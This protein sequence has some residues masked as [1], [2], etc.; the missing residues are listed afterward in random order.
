MSLSFID[1]SHWQSGINVAKAGVGGAIA[2]ATDG[3][4]MV[5]TTCDTYVRQAKGAGMVWGVYHFAH[6][7]S[8]AEA[9]FFLRNTTG[10]H[11]S[12][13][14]VLDWEG[15]AVTHGPAAAKRWLDRVHAATGVRPWIYMSRS[16]TEEYDWSAV[17]RDYGLWVA[18][19]GSSSYG[20][21]GKFAH[22][23]A[24]QY[25][26]TGRVPGYS[27]NV[28]LDTFYG[29]RTAWA[30]YATGGKNT[31]DQDSGDDDMPTWKNVQH[32][33][34]WQITADGDW[35]TVRT[36][37]ADDGGTN[38]SV[39]SADAY[40]TGTLHLTLNGLAKGH[41]VD[42]RTVL[43]DIKSGQPAKVAVGGSVLEAFAGSDTTQIELPF[44]VHVNDG[45]AGWIR[46]LRFQIRAFGGEKV[47]ITG[48]HTRLL[49]WPR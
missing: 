25:T 39:V 13:I 42:L 18:R 49:Y 8:D 1:V 34:D 33:P 10:Y 32:T 29:D 22:P 45:P 37:V 48:T 15:D 41:E 19:Y 5:D 26:S 43:V 27:G 47:T 36:E 46:R 11:G 2:K 38:Y 28:D 3:T 31:P 6:T 14:L 7:G 17:A 30:A 23:A 20:S 4:T 40:V 12:G 9:D 24:W 35:H 16:V 21:T 44:T